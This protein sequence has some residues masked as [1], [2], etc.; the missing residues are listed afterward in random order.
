VLFTTDRSLSRD[1]LSAAA[2]TLGASELAV[3]RVVICLAE[4]PMLGTGKTDYVALKAL[5]QDGG[6]ARSG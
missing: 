3:P 2:K 5:A 6:S 1:R 4:I